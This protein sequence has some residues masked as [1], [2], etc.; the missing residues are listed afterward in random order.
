[1][2][3]VCVFFNAIIEHAIKEHKDVQLGIKVKKFCGIL[4]L[5]VNKCHAH[6]ERLNIN[7]SSKPT[8]TDTL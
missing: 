6:I 2:K 5:L 8:Y 4:D 7:I 1:M 3:L